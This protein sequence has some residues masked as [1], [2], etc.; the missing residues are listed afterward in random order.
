[1][2]AIRTGINAHW[3]ADAEYGEAGA[4]S[5]VVTMMKGSSSAC[6]L[7][8]QWLSARLLAF[9]LWK[10]RFSEPGFDNNILLGTDKYHFHKGFALRLGQVPAARHQMDGCA[11]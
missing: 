4:P 9:A 10:Q 3:T 1:M 7:R 8:L 5:V 2:L 6:L 11:N